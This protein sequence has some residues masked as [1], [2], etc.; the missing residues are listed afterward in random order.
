MSSKYSYI[1]RLND[2]SFIIS[3]YKNRSFKASII[4]TDKFFDA[5]DDEID[6]ILES[7]YF[8]FEYTGNCYKGKMLSICK[9][10]S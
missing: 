9:F 3:D 1:K 6:E 5:S 8:I 2:L 10:Y 7:K 4:A